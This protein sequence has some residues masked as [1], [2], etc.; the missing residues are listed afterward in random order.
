MTITEQAVSLLHQGAGRKRHP[1]VKRDRTETYAQRSRGERPADVVAVAKAYR[2]KNGATPEN[3]LDDRHGSTIGQLHLEGSI[4]EEQLYTAQR[5]A[6][7]VIQNA[8]LFG[9]PSP[10][11]RALDLLMASKGLSCDVD[12]SEEEANLIKGRFRDC[13]RELLD[14]GKDLLVGSAVNRIV[15]GVVIEDWPIGAMQAGDLQNLR[16]G[17]NVLGKT[18]KS[19]DK[20]SCA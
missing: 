11:P 17:L 15:Y 19:W 16:C 4:S 12:I 8:K 14:C 9:I 2:V 20:R 10:H 6:T 3:A 5:Y 7:V 13:R 18:M 1:H